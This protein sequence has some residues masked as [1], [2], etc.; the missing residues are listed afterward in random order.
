MDVPLTARQQRQQ[1]IPSCAKPC[2]DYF[3]ATGYSCDADD[4]S[5]LCSR[6]SS[7]GLTLGE[8]AYG[9]SHFECE[10]TTEADNRALYNICSD[11]DKVVSATHST[12]TLPAYSTSYSAKE[13]PAS[14]TLSS[15]PVPATLTP[16]DVD[17]STG[18]GPTTSSSS[19]THEPATGP[20]MLPADG[21]S[22]RSTNLTTAQAVGISIAAM[23]V[24]C[25][26][27]AL[28]WLLTWCKRR[29]AF[30]SPKA[31]NDSF[32]FIDKGAPRHS[33]FRHGYADPR[34]PLGGFAKPRA[35]L[36]NGASQW[37]TQRA[38]G[39][40]N[41][42]GLQPPSHR[43]VSPESRSQDSLRTVSQLLPEKAGH[44]PPQPQYRSPR[45]A[46]V[47]ST[48]TIF[49]EDGKT[50]KLLSPATMLPMPMAPKAVL[51]TVPRRPE[52]PERPVYSAIFSTS[53]VDMRNP[54]S[55]STSPSKTSICSPLHELVLLSAVG[56]AQ[57][58][59]YM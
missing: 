23:G 13:T 35:E 2:L 33:P 14:S 3:K 9:C 27:G 19:Q 32:D 12:V 54:E 1:G 16:S 10:N 8:L 53:P 57:R 50:P 49:E 48:A 21:S 44:T 20:P 17:S 34:G 58:S 18:V 6:Y 39:P 28:I 29:R 37:Y 43:S 36:D 59:M 52:R 47:F 55:V 40:A 4:L 22:E 11:E 25:L 5:C 24:L 31:R 15:S 26:V 51:K 42:A 7:Q 38:P 45:A 30:K 56:H 46:S 41:H